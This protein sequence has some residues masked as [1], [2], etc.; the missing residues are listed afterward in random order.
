[1]RVI[2]EA[3]TDSLRISKLTSL[4]VR[5]FYTGST[6]PY[7][8]LYAIRYISIDRNQ[9]FKRPQANR[10]AVAQPDNA[11]NVIGCEF[12]FLSRKLNI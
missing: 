6:L 12:D 3:N 11:A 1:M 8:L 5:I 2:I 10:G 9:V 7:I 4:R